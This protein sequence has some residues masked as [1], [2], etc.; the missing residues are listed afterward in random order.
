V[1]L[2]LSG[3]HARDGRAEELDE[4]RSRHRRF[5]NFVE[6]DDGSDEEH[7]S[8]VSEKDGDAVVAGCLAPGF[9]HPIEAQLD[10]AVRTPVHRAA[11]LNPELTEPPYWSSYYAGT[12]SFVAFY[13]WRAVSCAAK[14]ADEEIP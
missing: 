13:R 3:T 6:I 1:R 7:L 9:N 4:S 8:P 10:G 5:E 12:S 11:Y 14:V 2:P